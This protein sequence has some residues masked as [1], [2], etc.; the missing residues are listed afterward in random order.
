M[1]TSIHDNHILE[2]SVDAAHRTIR[3]R[4][5]FPNP[6]GPEFTDVVFEG[7]EA[8]TFRGDALGT[9]LFDIESVDALGLYREYA[10]EMQLYCTLATA[11]T[12]RGRA[13][14]RQR[15]SFWPMMRFGGT[16]CRHPS[17]STVQSGRD[18]S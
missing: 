14:I 2:L 15:K 17:A 7:V 11:V 1:A 10:A 4:T 6:T 12:P 13:V 8:Y 18:G 9:I 3:I 16:S 5:A